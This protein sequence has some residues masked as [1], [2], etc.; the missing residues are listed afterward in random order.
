MCLVFISLTIQH[1]LQRHGF[2]AS[3]VDPIEQELERSVRLSAERDL[4]SKQKQLALSYSRFGDSHAILQILLTPSPTASERFVAVKP[5]HRLHTFHRSV[6]AQPEHRAVVK[7]YVELV[8]HPVSERVAAIDAHLKHRSRNVVFL[9]LKRPLRAVL[10]SLHQCVSDR[11][12]GAVTETGRAADCKNR[13][14]R[15]EKL[16]QPRN[17][18]GHGHVAQPV[19]KLSRCALRIRHSAAAPTPSAW[20]AAVARRNASVYKDEHVELTGQVARIERR[21]IDDR[22]WKLVLLQQPA[23]PA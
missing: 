17:G 12:A 4:R 22:E 19:A 18:P 8:T 13:S 10:R 14:A 5:C 6:G 16:P 1:S 21:R 15:F 20:T 9:A 23:H 11:Q 3:V 2:R 7:E